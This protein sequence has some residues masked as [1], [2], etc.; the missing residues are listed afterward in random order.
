MLPVSQL[1]YQGSEELMK[2]NTTIIKMK[3]CREA[4]MGF[5]EELATA[6][7]SK[8]GVLHGTC[9]G[10]SGNDFINQLTLYYS[11]SVINDLFSVSFVF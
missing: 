1:F 8:S 4:Y 7:C 9:Q 11:Q 10:D 2:G 6:V 5:K 3:E